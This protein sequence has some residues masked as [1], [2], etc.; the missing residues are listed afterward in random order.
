M[1]AMRKLLSHNL[2][3]GFHSTVKYY[4]AKSQG[5]KDTYVL[6]SDFKILI[7]QASCVNQS[8]RGMTSM[9]YHLQFR[10]EACLFL[11]EF[12]FIYISNVIPFP[13]FPSGNSFLIHLLHAS[14][15][16]LHPNSHLITLAFPY[17]V[18]SGLHRTK[19]LFSH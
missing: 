3:V 13:G 12:L 6:H 10:S 5:R 8:D 14:M 2:L 9:K 4:D 15:R 7:C 11:L 19:D 16:M 17:I 18:A 1:E